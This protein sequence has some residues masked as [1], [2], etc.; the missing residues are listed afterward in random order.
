[1]ACRVC[2]LA[3]ISTIRGFKSATSSTAA[4]ARAL[5]EFSRPLE[6]A[7]GVKLRHCGNSPHNFPP[8]ALYAAR[9]LLCP[10]GDIESFGFRHGGKDVQREAV[11]VRIV[12]R[13]ECHLGFHQ[14]PKGTPRF[15]QGGQA[16]RR[17]ALPLRP[18][19]CECLAKFRTVAI[20]SRS[21][22]RYT[23]AATV[24]PWLLA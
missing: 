18:S 21:P 16:W 22:L 9:A 19:V 12:A 1:M 2:P 15:G 17:P 5:M 8:R 11:G 6:I 13:N 14:A 7:S 4:L 10:L 20:A 3:R 23:I 24:P